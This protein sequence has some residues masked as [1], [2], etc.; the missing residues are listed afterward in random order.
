MK[1]VGISEI[2]VGDICQIKY[3]DLLPA[4]GLL[5]QS[6]D[7]KVSFRRSSIVADGGSDWR[8]RS[9]DSPAFWIMDSCMW[10]NVLHPLKNTWH[11]FTYLLIH[12]FVFVAE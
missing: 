12:G 1:Q 7:L 8:S 4:D 3:G 6:N 11:I 2:V 5:L 10:L 9:D